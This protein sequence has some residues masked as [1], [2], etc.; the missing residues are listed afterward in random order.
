MQW[1]H[2]ESP[3][4]RRARS[5]V[6]GLHLG[7]VICSR[8]RHDREALHLWGTEA[9]EHPADSDYLQ[10][11]LQSSKVMPLP[12]F[13]TWRSKRCL[14]LVFLAAP[15]PCCISLLPALLLCALVHAD[16]HTNNKAMTSKEAMEGK[17][18]KAAHTKIEAEVRRAKS[19]LPCSS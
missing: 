1:R 3:I 16:A 10:P 5:K 11:V 17:S 4:R 7:E 8:G 14:S 9:G 6:R 15:T 2:S 12:V 13:P 18:A 19:K